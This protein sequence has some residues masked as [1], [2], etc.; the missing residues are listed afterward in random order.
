MAPRFFPRVDFVRTHAPDELQHGPLGNMKCRYMSQ[1][2]LLI[3]KG[4]T[5]TA[6]L[7]VKDRLFKLLT[8]E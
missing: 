2:N 5:S 1:A 7:P 8:S 3:A 4:V 6:G